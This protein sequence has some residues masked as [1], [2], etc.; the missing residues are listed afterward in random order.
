MSILD[1]DENIDKVENNVLTQV[2]LEKEWFRYLIPF[3]C[4]IG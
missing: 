2:E 4:I 3:K 1:V